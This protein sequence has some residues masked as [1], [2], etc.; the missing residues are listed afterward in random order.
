MMMRYIVEGSHLLERIRSGGCPE[1]AM[2][3]LLLSLS[4]MPRSTSAIGGSATRHVLSL[5]LCQTRN[6]VVILQESRCIAAIS[7]ASL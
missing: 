2:A 4:S 7:V 1:G 3:A 6:S 5:R